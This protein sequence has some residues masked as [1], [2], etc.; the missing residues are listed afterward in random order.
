MD[1]LKTEVSSMLVKIQ[2]WGNSQGLRLAK[3]ILESAQ[4]SIG[5]DLEIIVGENEIVLKKKTQPK[6]VLADLVR[7]M[8]A[9]YRPE[10]D[11]FGKSVGNE[12]L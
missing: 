6:F 8:P 5:D 10:A 2:K 7:K 3:H 4:I 12:E 9:N 1:S 11:P